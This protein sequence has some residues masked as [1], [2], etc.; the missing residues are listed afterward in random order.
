MAEAF[1]EGERDHLALLVG[2]DAERLAK[3]LLLLCGGEERFRTVA[4]GDVFE[5][6]GLFGGDEA[7]AGL[8]GAP[9]I[10]GTAAR[11]HAEP[12]G[13]GAAIRI[14]TAGQPPNLL[15]DVESDFVGFVGVAEDTQSYRMHVAVRLIVEIGEGARVPS[16]DL[17]HEQRPSI[18]TG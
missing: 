4:R 9:S 14:V 7:A 15:E 1:P 10:E 6:F 3:A 12:A 8:D 18:R 5:A 11:H 2:E 16:R 13:D 17:H